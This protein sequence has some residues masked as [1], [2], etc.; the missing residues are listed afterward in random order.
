MGSPNVGEENVAFGVPPTPNGTAGQ[1]SNAPGTDSPG[2]RRSA[3]RCPH[4]VSAS[5]RPLTFAIVAYGRGMATCPGSLILHRGCSVAG[6]TL[7]ELDDDATCR[8][9]E[10]RHERDRQECWR[11]FGGC[12]A[13]GVHRR[14]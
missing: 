5:P 1:Q 7:D 4:T 2:I 10:P 14:D 3:H 8:G 6:C 9:L 12:N 11:V 13:C